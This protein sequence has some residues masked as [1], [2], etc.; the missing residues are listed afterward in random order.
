MLEPEIRSVHIPVVFSAL[1]E[2]ITVGSNS[3]LHVRCDF[4]SNI[5]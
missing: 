5:A 4:I 2:L 1:A 3:P